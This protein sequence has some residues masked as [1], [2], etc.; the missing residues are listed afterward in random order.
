[1]HACVRLTFVLDDIDQ[2]RKHAQIF[3]RVYAC[4]MGAGWLGSEAWSNQARLL[5][6]VHSVH[7]MHLDQHARL[8]RRTD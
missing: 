2:Y 5:A 4:V 6:W 7:R 8:V 3:D 1:M